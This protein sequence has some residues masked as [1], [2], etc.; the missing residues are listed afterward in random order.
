MDEI[1]HLS[2]TPNLHERWDLRFTSICHLDHRRASEPQRFLYAT[3]IGFGLEIG[4]WGETAGERVDNLTR[5]S[6]LTFGSEDRRSLIRVGSG[7]WRYEQGHDGVRFI[8]GY[9]YQV[10]WGVLGRVF[11]R[12]AFRPLLG[13]ATAWSFDR[14]RLWIEAGV[15]PQRAARQGVVHALA[16]VS[17]AFV[18]L[19]HGIVPK[20]AGPHPNEVA[21]LL[22]AGV[23]ESW[24]VPLAQAHGM[25]EVAFGLAILL[26]ATRR[27]PWVLTMA[28]MAVAT[29]GVL[30]C[31]PHRALDAFGPITLNLL[32]AVVAAVGLLSLQDLP[33]ARRCSRRAPGCPTEKG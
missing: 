31:S 23:P 7:Y 24:S 3:R 33:S 15:E 5:T 1:W 10:R 8:T 30:I 27:W 6:A 13:W 17:L 21:M 19:W 12:L 16:T 26:F 29:V 22:E 9:D 20:L 28:L 11:D 18:W 4:G 32:L 25:A 14:L 2:Q